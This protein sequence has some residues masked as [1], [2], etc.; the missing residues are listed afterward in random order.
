MVA[1]L[2]VEA[3]TKRFGAFKALDQM[4]FV[5]EQGEIHA[6]CGEN[7]AGK[8]TLIRCLSGLWP[9]SSYDGQIWV[10]DQIAHF[11]GIKDA[12]KAGIAVIYQELALVPDMTVS[13]NLF[14]GA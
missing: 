13:E 5:L 1:A 3:L 12:E 2:R 4:S 8:S 10:A 9:H 11:S 6:L 7:G 14:L